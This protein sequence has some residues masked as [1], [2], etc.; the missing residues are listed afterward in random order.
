MGG[1]YR[2]PEFEMYFDCGLSRWYEVWPFGSLDE[3][4]SE[5][6]EGY[7]P[8]GAELAEQVRQGPVWKT[9]G[10]VFEDN[11]R[12]GADLLGDDVMH[13]HANEEVTRIGLPD[14]LGEGAC[15]E[16]IFES[17]SRFLPERD[18]G[19]PGS[20]A[21]QGQ[22]V[23]VV[24]GV[25]QGLADGCPGA[26]SD[27][28]GSGVASSGN[29]GKAG[30]HGFILSRRGPGGSPPASGLTRRNQISC[31]QIAEGPRSA[32]RFAGLSCLCAC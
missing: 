32:R 27:R 30:F 24:E 21:A 10:D 13:G 16:C 3:L 23:A 17:A 2:L 31:P 28:L 29:P 19:L 22:S 18:S 5:G 4:P 7:V 25:Q 12:H 1:S 6:F 9:A 8:S 20:V 11:R 15:E 26:L 14:E